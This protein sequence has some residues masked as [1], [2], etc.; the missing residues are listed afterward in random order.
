MQFEKLGNH[1]DIKECTGTILQ[2][3]ILD[4]HRD[5][6]ECAETIL[7]FEILDIDWN[8]TE[9]AGTILQFEIF[10]LKLKVFIENFAVYIEKVWSESCGL[11]RGYHSLRPLDCGVHGLY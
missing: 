2:F 11:Y 1:W 9:W 10:M 5:I 8:K 3:E 6:N 4:N 7:Q